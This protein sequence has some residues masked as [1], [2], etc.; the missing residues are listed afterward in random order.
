MAKEGAK[1]TV[2]TIILIVIIVAAVLSILARRG[3]LRPRGA[4]P[5]PEVETSAPVE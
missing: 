3:L 5:P 2:L 1:N 4:M